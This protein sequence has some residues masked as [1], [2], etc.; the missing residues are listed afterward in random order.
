MHHIAGEGGKKKA[1][2][3][4]AMV[5]GPGW[6]TVLDMPGIWKRTFATA[7]RLRTVRSPTAPTRGPVR[8]DPGP[9]ARP[10][11]HEGIAYIQPD[12]DTD[13]E[14]TAKVRTAPPGIPKEDVGH[15]L[16]ALYP[17]PSKTDLYKIGNERGVLLSSE[18][19]FDCN[20]RYLGT[21]FKTETWNHRFQAPPGT[22]GENV[23]CTFY[24]S[25]TDQTDAKLARDMPLYLTK[26]V[27]FGSPNARGS[28]P[29]W[30]VY[31]NGAK[32]TT[33]GLE[34]VGKDVDETRNK[35]C[36]CW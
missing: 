2:F 10:H 19:V 25:E 1:P 4:R 3:N 7:S 6:Q 29:K 28:L 20:T 35:R 9:D 17:P 26:F 8:R 21:A 31:G 5:Q 12:V 16:T 22:H 23:P 24:N 18:L 11:S 27:Q 14:I 33:S 36:E 30:P 32:L 34:G 13:A 15:I